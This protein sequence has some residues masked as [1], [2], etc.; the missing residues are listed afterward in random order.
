MTLAP[1]LCRTATHLPLSP[2][3]HAPQV[4]LCSASLHMGKA[5][6]ALQGRAQP[7]L[8][9]SMALLVHLNWPRA[10]GLQPMC[11]RWQEHRPSAAGWCTVL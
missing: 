3:L 2:L 7:R 4:S 5:G 1:L 11:M 8:L 10:L 6:A 9:L